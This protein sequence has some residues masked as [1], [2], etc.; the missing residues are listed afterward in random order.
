MLFVDW[1]RVNALYCGLLW[2]LA[3]VL[4][5]VILVH[6]LPQ[7]EAPVHHVVSAAVR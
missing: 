2:M 6:G 3:L 1:Q 4:G 7:G 5:L